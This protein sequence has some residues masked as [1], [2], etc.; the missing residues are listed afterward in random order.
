MHLQAPILACF[1]LL[2]VNIV[3][4][5]PYLVCWRTRIPYTKLAVLI[6]NYIPPGGT[7]DS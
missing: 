4:F 3:I 2:R 6:C 7:S 1:P 5:F